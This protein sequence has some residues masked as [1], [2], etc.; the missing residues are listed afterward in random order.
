MSGLRKVKHPTYYRFAYS[1]TTDEVVLGHN[2]EARHIDIPLHGDMA[3]H[4]PPPIVMGYAYRIKNG[5][6]IVNA[7]HKALDDPHVRELV[8]HALADAEP[9]EH[10]QP[11]EP[12][13]EWTDANFDKFHYGLPISYN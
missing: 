11:H 6:R 4:M 3:A 8:L 9:E 2:L 5:W 10:A 1:P 12:T 7:E 13:P